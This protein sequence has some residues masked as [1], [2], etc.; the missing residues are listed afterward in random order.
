MKQTHPMIKW[1]M[2]ILSGILLAAGWY[3]GAWP[4][5]IAFIPLLWL[6]AQIPAIKG[7][8]GGWQF[9]GFCYVALVTWNAGATWWIWN[10]TAGGTIFAIMANAALMCIPMAIYRRISAQ[11]SHNWAIVAFPALFVLFEFG[12]INWDLSWSWLNVGNAFAFQPWL[13]QWYEITG[14]LGGTWWVL[15]I[16]ILIYKGFWLGSKRAKV[17]LIPTAIIP[18]IATLLW[19]M[20]VPTDKNIEVVIVQP[21][22]DPYTEKFEDLPGY[23]PVEQQIQRF[24]T[25]SNIKRTPNTSYILWPETAISKMISED[26]PTSEPV[27]NQLQTWVDSLGSTAL[28]T[29]TN[30]WHHYTNIDSAPPTARRKEDFVYDV[31]NTA[32]LIQPNEAPQFYHKSKLVPGVEQMP[33]PAFFRFLEALVIDLGGTSGTY[34][35]QPLRSTMAYNDG[36]AAPVICYESA[37]GDFCSGFMRSGANF[38][39]II[40]NDAW[41]GNTPGHIHLLKYAQLRAIEFRRDIARSANTGISAIIRADGSVEQAQEFLT[42]SVISGNLNLY[43]HL[44]FYAR[45]GDYLGWVSLAYIL[46]VLRFARKKGAFRKR[47]DAW[48]RRRQGV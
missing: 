13:V 44:T 37:Y 47:V 1:L 20:P 43:S 29:G 9:I 3:V 35:K 45:F 18:V 2:A 14:T 24:I 38:I 21:N 25:L 4:L 26:M 11:A 7:K 34:G 36:M 15:V 42:T 12:H 10:S 32:M 48:A 39:A 6:N 30:T 5:F 28:L 33:Y 17:T 41:W 16:N 19:P 8:K 31:Y 27:Y 23:I 22:I 46:L 40:T